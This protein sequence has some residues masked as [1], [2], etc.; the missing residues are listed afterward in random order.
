MSKERNSKYETGNI[1]F[2]NETKQK[3]RKMA[4]EGWES[5]ERWGKESDPGL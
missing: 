4:G 3:T 5:G 2:N 1:E